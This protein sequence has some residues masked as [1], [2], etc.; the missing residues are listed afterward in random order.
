MDIPQNARRP[1]ATALV[2]VLLAMSAG[3]LSSCRSKVAPARERC[4]ANLRVLWKA[5]CMYSRDQVET[6]PPSLHHMVALAPEPGWYVCPASGHQPGD[7]NQVDAWSDYGYVSGLNAADPPGCVLAFCPPEHHKGEGAN[8]LLVDG[9]VRWC[10]ADEF[11]KLTNEPSLFL[12]VQNGQ[13]TAA[14]RSRTKIRYP[15]H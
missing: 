2:V 3:L 10:T 1:L 9:T 11:R 7:T 6:F 14:L 4:Q 12:G 8:V 15:R 5:A 13:N